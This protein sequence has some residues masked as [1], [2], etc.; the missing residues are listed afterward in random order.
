MA[1]T[2]INPAILALAIHSALAAGNIP[3]P[4]LHKISMTI[5]SSA[6]KSTKHP[7]NLF[8]PNQDTL[9][10]LILAA[11]KIH[12]LT[13]AE[14]DDLSLEIKK[15][16]GFDAYLRKLLTIQ[17]QDQKGVL[18]LLTFLRSTPGTPTE[19]PGLTIACA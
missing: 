8:H 18:M 3:L 11:K 12:L 1:A 10:Q 9:N 5:S 13:Q 4:H 6:T 14:L 16:G 15:T 7:Q 2:N 19:E 17:E